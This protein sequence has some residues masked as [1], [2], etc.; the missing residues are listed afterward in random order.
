MP[1]LVTIAILLATQPMKADEFWPK[2]IVGWLTMFGLISGVMAGTYGYMRALVNLNGL[3]QR[4]NE[5]KEEIKALLVIVNRLDRSTERLEREQTDLHGEVAKSRKASETC[6][7]DVQDLRAVT[8]GII[9]DHRREMDQK[10]FDVRERIAR[11]EA[12][13]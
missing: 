2:T 7:D 6:G 8:V 10:I 11:M 12:R 3:G 4:V 13:S 5:M 1:S 9:S